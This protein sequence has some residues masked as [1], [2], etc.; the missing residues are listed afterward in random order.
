MAG[1]TS[2]LQLEHH[3]HGPPPDTLCPQDLLPQS[4]PQFLS[5]R[6]PIHGSAM[7]NLSER[8]SSLNKSNSLLPVFALKG[9]CSQYSSIQVS[10]RLGVT[11]G[12]G[13]VGTSSPAGRGKNRRPSFTAWVE[14][15]QPAMA[16]LPLQHSSFSSSEGL[17]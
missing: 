14:G 10:Q 6:S 15:I 8:V 5:P 17:L 13:A 11:G 16:F 3:P 9:R 12:K 4:A 7:L 1:S 2:I